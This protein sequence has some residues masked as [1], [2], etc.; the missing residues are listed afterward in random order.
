MVSYKDTWIYVLAAGIL[1]II[2][3]STPSG[4]GDAFGGTLYVWWSSGVGY[5]AGGGNDLWYGGNAATLWTF[6]IAAF[7][8][9]LLLF[10]GIHRFRGMDFKWDWLV[11]LLVGIALIIFPILMLVYDSVSGAI[12][13]FGPIGVLIAGVLS[14][15]AFVMDK[16]LGERGAA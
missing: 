13:G 16:F 9:G 7:C 14:I 2:G 3:L 15:I 11:Y 10:Y 4:S 5:L 12:V 8:A 6:G 1:T